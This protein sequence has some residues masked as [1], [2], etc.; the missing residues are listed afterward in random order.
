MLVGHSDR[1]HFERQIGEHVNLLVTVASGRKSH[2]RLEGFQFDQLEFVVERLGSRRKSDRVGPYKPF[3]CFSTI[4]NRL[5]WSILRPWKTAVPARAGLGRHHE[6]DGR[7]FR[8]PKYS[9][10]TPDA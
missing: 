7:A 2:E 10:S 8:E 6:T 1:T 3:A 4:D 9:P 5:D